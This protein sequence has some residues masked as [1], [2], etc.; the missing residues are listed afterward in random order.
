MRPANSG[1]FEGHLHWHY[2]IRGSVGR[3]PSKYWLAISSSRLI[4]I[5]GVRLHRYCHTTLKYTEQIKKKQQKT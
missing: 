5:N 3:K 1:W 2:L 4:V